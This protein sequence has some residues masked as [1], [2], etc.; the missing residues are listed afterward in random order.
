MEANR[1]RCDGFDRVLFAKTLR[2]PAVDGNHHLELGFKDDTERFVGAT[3]RSIYALPPPS[4]S[5]LKR[6]R[7]DATGGPAVTD[8]GRPWQR[9]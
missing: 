9:R 7:N 3:E 8:R 1:A 5:T 4:A 6:A 2:D